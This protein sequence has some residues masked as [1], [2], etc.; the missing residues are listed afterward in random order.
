M[1]IKYFIRRNLNEPEMVECDTCHGTGK[2]T[3]TITSAALSEPKEGVELSCPVCNGCGKVATGKMFHYRVG[4]IFIY[5]NAKVEDNGEEK[6]YSLGFVTD[7]IDK[8]ENYKKTNQIT[9]FI[10]YPGAL[11]FYAKNEEL[12]D[13]FEEAQAEADKLEKEY[14]SEKARDNL[15]LV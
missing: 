7:D 1:I 10:D 2:I 12:Y 8:I 5:G 9:S 13:T 15:K 11:Q 14:T 6:E 3:G 4:Q